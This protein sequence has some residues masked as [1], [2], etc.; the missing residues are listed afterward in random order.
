M[1]FAYIMG[2]S[3][4]KLRLFFHKDFF[5]IS[6]LFPLFRQRPYFGRVKLLAETSELFTHAVSARHRPQNGVLWVHPSGDQKDGRGGEW[7]TGPLVRIRT[8][9]IFLFGRTLLTRCF[10][11][12]VYYSNNCYYYYYYYYLISLMSAHMALNWLWHLPPR[13]PL[14]KSLPFPKRRYS[15]DFT[16]SS[17]P[18]ISSPS[19]SLQ[20]RLSTL[21]LPP[22]LAS[23]RHST[24]ADGELKHS[25]REELQRFGKQCYATGI[26]HLR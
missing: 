10:N 16:H 8:W 7:Q 26:Q 5:I 19:F 2:T 13:I 17:S 25:V 9:I 11:F 21:R 12:L 15:H 18:W 24:N 20:S 6:T 23:W 1:T 14:T 22:S 3:F 4:T